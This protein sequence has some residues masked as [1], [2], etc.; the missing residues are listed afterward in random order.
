MKQIM[1]SEGLVL[2]TTEYKEQAVIAT[3]LTK[4]GLKNYIIRGAK[5]ISSGT[6]LLAIPLT[7]IVFNGTISNGLDTITEGIP[8]NN[9][10][11]IKQDINKMMFVYPIIEK[12]LTFSSQVVNNEIFYQF[13]YEILDLLQTNINSLLVLT[14][15]ELKLTYLIGIAPSIK[16]CINCG[17][18]VEDGVFSIS[19]GGCY[20]RKCMFNFPYDL[21]VS[22]TKMLKLLYLIKPQNVD[23][24]LESLVI[25]DLDTISHIVDLY[26]Q[27]YLDFISKAKPVASSILNAKKA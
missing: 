17:E 24:K 23:K 4:E 1:A 16:A 5:K 7:K 20:C 10:L 13:V 19:A 26:Y 27:R 18:K 11:T 6:R 8:Q 22:Q 21:N 14:I 2:K 25:D 15:F 12:I 9:Y 3:L